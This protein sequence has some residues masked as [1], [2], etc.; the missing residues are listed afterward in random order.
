MIEHPE[1]YSICLNGKELQ[2]NDCG[3][4][5]DPALRK[6]AI[7]AEFLQNGENQLILSG[8]YHENLPGLESIFILGEFGVFEN[9]IT[10]LPT[11]VEWGDWCVQGFPA[12]GGNFTYRM[13]VDA[14]K[15]GRMFLNIPEWRG[16]A[17]G[18]KVNGSEEQLLFCPPFRAEI[19]DDL[20]YD[21]NDFAEIC[22]YGHRRN[23]FGPFYSLEK[24]PPWTGPAQFKTYETEKRQTVPCGI[25]ADPY[26]ETMKE[27]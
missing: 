11:T 4:W 23:V 22:I 20:K 13:S 6:L 8:K 27:R 16:T 2:K 1:L 3:Y 5:I 25:L 7:P 15:D 9:K 26:I 24:W 12:Y 10:K 18:I 14:E 17:I 19:T 21:G